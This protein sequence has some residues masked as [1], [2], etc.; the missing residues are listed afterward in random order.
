MGLPLVPLLLDI[1]FLSQFSAQLK[2]SS[3]KPD[4]SLLTFSQTHF[5]FINFCLVRR[6][7]ILHLRS[8]ALFVGCHLIDV[9]LFTLRHLPLQ[10]LD[11][12]LKLFNLLQETVLIFL[13]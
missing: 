1:S 7:L 3:L 9:L 11:F 6:S 5:Q 2:D 10:L 8:K 13:L 12:V 4:D